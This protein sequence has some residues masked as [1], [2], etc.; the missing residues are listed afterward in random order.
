M[1]YSLHRVVTMSRV[2]GPGSRIQGQGS[3]V[4]GGNMSHKGTKVI[5]VISKSCYISLPS[6]TAKK[7][8]YMGAGDEIGRRR[9]RER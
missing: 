9:G 1:P 8:G 4:K 7:T 5:Y 2:E 3:R 6:H